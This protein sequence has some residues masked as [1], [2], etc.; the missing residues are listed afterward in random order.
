MN[1]FFK[2]SATQ[3]AF[4]SQLTLLQVDR[5]FGRFRRPLED[6]DEL[7][8]DPEEHVDGEGRAAVP[9]DLGARGRRPVDELDVVVGAAVVV[10]DLKL[11]SSFY[12]F[13]HAHKR[14]IFF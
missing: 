8:T 11:I 9:P 6:E 1:R 10:R 7:C 4:H 5:E 3:F 2:R 12:A 14:F 13:A